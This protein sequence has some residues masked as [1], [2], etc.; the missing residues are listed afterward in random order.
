MVVNGS[1]YESWG[2]S[3]SASFV[4]PP[5]VRAAYFSFLAL[6]KSVS[7][8]YASIGLVVTDMEYLFMSVPFSKWEEFVK[9]YPFVQYLGDFDVL[10]RS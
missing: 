10:L 6:L 5:L 1:W 9:A 3:T 2:G 4:S 8:I 7:A